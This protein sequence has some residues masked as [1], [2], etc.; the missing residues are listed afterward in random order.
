MKI[1]IINGPNLDKL[2][3]RETEK[4]GNLTLNEI[5]KQTASRTPNSVEIEWF[6]SNIEGELVEKIHE[7]ESFNGIIINPAA[8]SHTSVALY[9][10]L[11]MVNIPK[12]EVHLTNI[13]KREEFRH[14]ML[15][16]RAC[17]TIMSGLGTDVYYM[18]I[19][20]ILLSKGYSFEISNN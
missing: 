7:W 14:V 17:D 9:D 13:Y 6:Q 8:Y 2:G 18:G 12:I 5:I 16:A 3:S 4:Y 20:K 1:L 10:A 19:V 11:S 15:T